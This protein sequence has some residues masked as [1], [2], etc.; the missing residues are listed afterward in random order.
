ML[1]KGILITRPDGT[2]PALFSGFPYKVIPV[3]PVS[4]GLWLTRPKGRVPMPR[5]IAELFRRPERDSD[6]FVLH[7]RL[8]CVG[9]E[10]HSG[11]KPFVS[12]RR[13]RRAAGA[14]QLA[15]RTLEWPE[16]ALLARTASTPPDAGQSKVRWT[17]PVE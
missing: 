11:L 8:Y 12:E 2:D 17:K 5:S 4:D 10:R 3:E 13:R 15:L 9:W 7:G 1:G 14:V 16:A 6:R